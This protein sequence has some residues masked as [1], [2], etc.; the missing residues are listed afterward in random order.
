MTTVT[1][2]TSTAVVQVVSPTS[3]TVNVQGAATAV[4][5]QD[6][7]TVVS[8]LD[9]VNT[10]S[11]PAFIQFNTA[12]TV[13]DA[14]GRLYWDA[15]NETL[16]L[17]VNSGAVLQL[18]QEM[19]QIVQNDSG[20]TIPDGTVVAVQLDDQGRIRTVG[21][22]IMRVVKAQ[23]NGSLPAKLILG[24]ATTNMDN[25]D[26]GMVTSHGYVN[27]LNTQTPGWTLG[28]IL[29]V[30]GTTPGALTNVEPTAPALRVP[31]AVVTRVNQNTGSIYVRYSPNED[32]AQL[33]DVAIVSPQEGD[34]LVYRS[35]VWTNEAGA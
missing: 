8:N 14:T 27:F 20:S 19:H 10:I 21:Q 18:G 23:G 16:Q 30:S 1:V 11:S 9:Q 12:A 22:G 29:W 32:L 34:V 3:A 31:I 6:Q 25:G 33:N 24:V 28:D 13:T 2:T 17:G 7:A 35:G 26:R 15:E 5:N 4:V